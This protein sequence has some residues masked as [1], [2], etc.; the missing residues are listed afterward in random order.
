MRFP[1]PSTWIPST[2]IGRPS[3]RRGEGQESHAGLLCEVLQATALS[4]V[5]SKY[6]WNGARFCYWHLPSKVNGI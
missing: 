6:L 5:Q 2:P 3:E 1:V 4:E